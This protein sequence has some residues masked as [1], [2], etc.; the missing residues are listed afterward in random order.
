MFTQ[1]KFRIGIV[2]VGVLVLAGSL[3][4]WQLNA[5]TRPDKVFDRM[6]HNALMT[7]S[8]VKSSD[9]ASEAQDVRQVT[10]LQTSPDARV[11]ALV[12]INQKGEG[13]SYVKRESLV[14]QTNNFVRLVNVRT[15]QVGPTGKPYDFSSILGV[16]AQSPADASN[17]SLTQLYGQNVAVP[18][19]HL[20]PANRKTVLDQIYRDQVYKID[21]SKVK[22]A[23]FNGRK[24]YV[25]EVGVKPVA[26]INMMKTVGQL[27]GVKDYADVDA[28]SYKNLP[29]VTFTIVVD[30]LSADLV[31]VNYGNDQVEN[32]SG[33]GLRHIETDPK[34]AVSTLEL[35]QRL[36]KLQQ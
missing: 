24:A 7:S 4:A 5:Q 6:L 9:V 29:D 33:V 2:I 15:S 23:R 17:N 8:V 36:Q 30:A 35:Q 22:E 26:F 21:Y 28:N 1:T 32:Y 14:T 12:E 19:A 34:N 20:S 27:E 31:Q 11:H 18:Y 25:Y 3:G 13:G 16:W 10:H